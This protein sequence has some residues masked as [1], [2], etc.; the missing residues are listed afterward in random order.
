MHRSISK[1]LIISVAAYFAI[2]F[3]LI[4]S[5]NPA[6][7]FPTEDKGLSFDQSLEQD[8]SDLPASQEYTTRSADTLNY[9]LYETSVPTDKVMIL[10]H[11]SAWHGMQFHSLAK[12]LAKIGVAQIIVPD[13]RGH[14]ENPIRR[15][16]ID[17]IG[18]LEDDLADL[19]DLVSK[20]N[21][22]I[23]VAGHSSGGGLAI[24]FAGGAHNAKADAFIL[25]APFLKYNAPTTRPDSGGWAQP[26]TRRIIGLSMLNTVGINILND[27]PM[28]SFAMPSKVL[29]GPLGHT[30]TT[31]YSYRLNTSFAPRNDFEADIAALKQPFLLMA[32]QADES[33]IAEEYQK[34]MQPLTDSGDYMLF[35]GVNHLGLV[36]DND[37]LLAI[38]EWL[39]K[40]L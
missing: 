29:S 37:A 18:Q 1:I 25:M 35:E 33:F 20:P 19:I 9:R 31:M 2:A 7:V 4:V 36:N 23:I 26:A 15:G 39:D 10:L 40:K 34:L 21:S 28:I 3:L 11:G 38:V 8:Y 30:A 16:D 24:R 32:G 14:G 12:T 13:L 6:S 27:L 22:K 5:Q 17:Y